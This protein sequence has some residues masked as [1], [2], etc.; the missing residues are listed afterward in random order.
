MPGGA[1]KIEI[2]SDYSVYMTGE[3]KRVGTVVLSD[4]FYNDLIHL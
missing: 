4:E 3:V 1:L 2:S